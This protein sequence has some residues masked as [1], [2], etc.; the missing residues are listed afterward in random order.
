MKRKWWTITGGV[1]LAMLVGQVAS[2][3]DRIVVGTGVD[4][5]L[6]QIYLG[7]EAGIFAK[8]DLDVEVKLFG[9]ATA[10][11]PSLIPGDIQVSLTSVPG[12]AL[13]H[14]KADKIVLVGLA[15]VLKNYQGIV[16]R[17]GI[18]SI[19]DMR[20]KKIGVAIGTSLE[21]SSKQALARNNMTYD[22]VEIVNVEPPEMLAAFLRDDIDG[23]FV[24]EPW[25]TRGRLGSDGKG[26]HIPGMEFFVVNVHLTLD[27]EWAEANWD[28][29]VRFVRAFKEAGELARDNPEEA[30][31][32]VAK[33]LKLDVELTKALLPKA[34]FVLKLD[35]EALGVL[36]SEVDILI[37]DKRLEGPFNYETY[38]YPG[39][40]REVDPSAVTY[41]DL[42][43]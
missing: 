17:D 42:P 15:A 24:W 9:S 40:L 27:R 34:E 13:G 33:F 38:V 1:I 16:V 12:G 28:A 20:G 11:T 29:A 2:A 5:S 36:K 39:L 10:S 35:D 7:V 43:Q 6:S 41:T 37:A 32:M 14:G 21:I 25:L 3:A 31:P 30:A 4:P 26:H 8:H 18:D 23:F 22:D 19:A